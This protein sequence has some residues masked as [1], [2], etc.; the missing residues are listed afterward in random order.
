MWYKLRGSWVP[1]VCVQWYEWNRVDAV[2]DDARIPLQIA[3]A[4]GRRKKPP[5]LCSNIPPVELPDW[6]EW[7]QGEN[8]GSGRVLPARIVKFVRRLNLLRWRLSSAEV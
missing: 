8:N 1:A 6:H 3:G 4:R 7:W 5:A 2:C